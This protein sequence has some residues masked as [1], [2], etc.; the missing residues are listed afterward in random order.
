MLDLIGLSFLIEGLPFWGEPDLKPMKTLAWEELALFSFDYTSPS[1]VETQL[2]TYLQRL[3]DG[4]SSR[5][6]HGVWLASE[7]QMLAQHQGKIPQS[8]A[9]LT[10][11]AT[12]LAALE[13]YGAD[14]QF[15]TVVKKTGAVKNGVL[16]G[17]LIIEGGGD[18]FFIWEEAIAL[19][20]TLNDAGIKQVKGD[21]IVTGDFFMNYK[22]DRATS[23][24][25]LAQALHHQQWSS[26]VEKQYQKLPPDTP[27]PAVEI[28]GKVRQ[29]SNAAGETIIRHHSLP[30]KELLHRM[31]I[32]SNNQMAELIARSLGGIERVMEIVT[33][34]TEIPPNEIQLINASGLGRENRLS[35]RAVFKL[36]AAIEEH[37]P[38]NGV[39]AILP[40]GGMETGTVR[41]RAIP[42]GIPVKTGTLNKVSSLAGAI[43]TKN[44]GKIYF[45]IMNQ[46]GNVE[47]F[48]QQ[49]EAL[50]QELAQQWKISS[51]SQEDTLR[52]GNPERI[53]IIAPL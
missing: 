26:A 11:L 33:T 52:V 3:S 39:A 41:D 22:R 37:F 4:G 45:V 14:Y 25:L 36:L 10:K 47:T 16:Q 34:T 32:Y 7:W 13:T 24:K 21:L 2:Q 38:A 48:R 6:S 20:N 42:N 8:A 28:S 15:E 44:H 40:R 51:L 19:G 23:A 46:N 9:S 30:L 27:R 18:P 12:S 29:Q 50:L 49:Q 17:D 43:P 1:G 5:D 35:P 53:N 31:N